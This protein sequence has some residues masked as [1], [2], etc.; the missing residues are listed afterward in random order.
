MSLSE[1]K[2]AVSYASALVSPRWM[3]DDEEDEGC[4]RD[5]RALVMPMFSK[6][7]ARLS[8]KKLVRDGKKVGVFGS[9]RV[10]RGSRSIRSNQGLLFVV[11]SS[12]VK[13]VLCR[14]MKTQRT[15][16]GRVYGVDGCF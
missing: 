3:L 2:V 12:Q 11:K 14:K 15:K 6:G 9:Y 1:N 5:A 13:V 4:R 7:P 10:V 8:L 16:D